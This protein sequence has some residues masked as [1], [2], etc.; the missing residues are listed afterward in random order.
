MGQKSVQGIQLKWGQR[1]DEVDLT[2]ESAN[3]L[4]PIPE[5][6]GTHKN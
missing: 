1:N 6:P 5:W 2:N 4:P 3:S